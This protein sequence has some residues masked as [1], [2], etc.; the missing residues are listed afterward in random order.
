M[1]YQPGKGLGKEG[2][3]CGLLILNIKLW[4]SEGDFKTIYIKLQYM[5]TVGHTSLAVEAAKK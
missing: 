2:Q 3:V 5:Y 4:I 1:G